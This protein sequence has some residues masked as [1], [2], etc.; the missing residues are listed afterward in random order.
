MIYEYALEPEMV[1]KWGAYHIAGF[2]RSQFGVDQGRF[3]SCYPEDWVKKVR[4]SVQN[5]DVRDVEKNRLEVLLEL[6]QENMVKRT[7]C[8]WDDS[9]RSWLENALTEH[10]RFPFRAIMAR[11]NTDN[12]PEII[13]EDDLFLSTPPYKGWDAPHGITIKRNASE[14]ASAIKMMLTC[15]CCVKFIDPYISPGNPN[16]RQSLRAFLNI[17][18]NKRPVGPLQ[19]IEIHTGMHNGTVD[20]LRKSYGEIIPAGLQVTLF[21]W[22]ERPGGQKLHNR[23]VLTDLGGVS[24]HHGLAIGRDGETDDITRLSKEQFELR[25]G[26]YS[27]VTS[28]FDEAAE[29]M[30]LSKKLGKQK[31]I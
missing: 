16:Y 15:C 25:D 3:V 22:K 20:F 26:E 11:K 31:D 4:N 1:A 9:K 7:K 30:V 17:L 12:L 24:F 27:R 19:A 13:C 29:P 28:A 18:A 23:Y 21:Q 2:F 14:M 8:C 6:L 5:Q 10:V